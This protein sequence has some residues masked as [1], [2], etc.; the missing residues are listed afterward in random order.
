MF[1]PFLVLVF[2]GYAV[3]DV[4]FMLVVHFD[5]EK[6]FLEI[7]GSYFDLFVGVCLAE[8]LRYLA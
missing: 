4:G 6:L 2:Y 1:Y 3:G 8:H 5:K 7:R